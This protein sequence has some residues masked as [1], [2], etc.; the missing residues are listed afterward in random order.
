MKHF[1]RKRRGGV[2]ENSVE[3]GGIVEE[4]LDID[5]KKTEVSHIPIHKETW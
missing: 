3:I 2:V 4:G 5:V 1:G